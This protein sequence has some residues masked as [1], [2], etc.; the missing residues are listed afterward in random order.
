MARFVNAGV[1]GPNGITS[2]TQN[3]PT[4]IEVGRQA[5]SLTNGTVNNT[6]ID[7]PLASGDVFIIVDSGAGYTTDTDRAVTF[8]QNTFTGQA[9]GATTNSTVL[10]VNY[11]ASTDGEISRG[12]GSGVPQPTVSADSTF[13]GG[14]VTGLVSGDRFTIDHTT[15]ETDAGGTR[16]AI[17]EVP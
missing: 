16:S 17:L 8:V 7:A 5:F 12:G 13:S 1:D 3:P 2:R 6:E 14:F 4:P 11:T 15:A 10:L 9:A